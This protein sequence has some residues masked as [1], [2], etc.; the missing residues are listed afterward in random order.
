[1]SVRA[2]VCRVFQPGVVLYF[3][4][5]GVKLWTLTDCQHENTY[6]ELTTPVRKKKK[7]QKY[8]I[9][10]SKTTVL[11]TAVFNCLS[12][13]QHRTVPL[14]SLRET[15]PCIFHKLFG[16]PRSQR[17]CSAFGHDVKA[18]AIASRCAIIYET[19]L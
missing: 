2:N 13:V 9:N 14:L 1:M 6:K 8:R 15:A 17:I 18:L 16:K 3:E 10:V 4:A 5:N 11:R 12:W 19:G 7:Q